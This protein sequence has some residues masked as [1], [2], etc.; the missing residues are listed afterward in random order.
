MEGNRI[1]VTVSHGNTLFL[2]FSSFFFLPR[3]ILV[4]ILK[5]P[6]PETHSHSQANWKDWSPYFSVQEKEEVQRKLTLNRDM[7]YIAENIVLFF[8]VERGI[9]ESRN[10]KGHLNPSPNTFCQ[11]MATHSNMKKKKKTSKIL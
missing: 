1:R 3:T 2:F 6:N 8:T 4:F 11:E 7:P 10:R 9:F 5:V